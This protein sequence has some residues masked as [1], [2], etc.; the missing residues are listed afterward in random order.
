MIEIAKNTG[1][2]ARLAKWLEEICR[3][4][5]TPDRSKYAT[6]RLRVWLDKEPMLFHPFEVKPAL[7]VADGVMDRLRELINWPFDFCLVTYSGDINPAGILPHRDAGYADFEAYGMHVTGDVKFD[8]WC[9]RECFGAGPSTGKV[10]VKGEP[11][12][13]LILRPGDVVRFNCK[14]QHSASPGVKRWN[15]NFWKAKPNEMV[16]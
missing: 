15:L 4:A 11:S 14:N 7:Q 6:G 8:Y 12:H 9:Q 1:D 5:L 3:P 10:D 16:K 2:T 13:S